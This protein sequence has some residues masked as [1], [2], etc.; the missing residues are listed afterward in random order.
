MT[1]QSIFKIFVSHSHKDN[2]FG[3]QLVYD[4]HHKLGN[5]AKIWYD[6]AGGLDSGDEW[7]TKILK[8]LVASS[9]FI[10][11]LTPEAM[12]SKWV[13]DEITIAWAHKNSQEGKL[14][15]PIL[16]RECKIRDDLRTLHIV[17]FLDSKPYDV[18]LD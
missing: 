14:I 4:L 15:I 6:A 12:A 10:V 9:V 3:I 7:W 5:N 18:A 1:N 2:Q 13:N 17:S 8:E 11:V 16:Y